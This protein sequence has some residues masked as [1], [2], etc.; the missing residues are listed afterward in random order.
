[1]AVYDKVLVGRTIKMRSM[2]ETDAEITYKMRNDP[3]KSK[4]L[5]APPKSAEEQRNYIAKQRRTPGDYYFMIED[6]NGKPIGMKALTNYRP[7]EKIIESGR[8]MGFGNQVQHLEA[9]MMGFDFA[10]EVLKVDKVEMTVIENNENMHSLQVRMGAKE[11]GR[12][13]MP[14]FGCDSIRLELTKEDY[15]SAR[16]KAEKLIARFAGRQ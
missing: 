11:T 12:V 10:F 7:K 16:E 3:E 8:F 1:M 4:F 9:L 6:L 15:L 14:N 5:N 13:Y 2:E